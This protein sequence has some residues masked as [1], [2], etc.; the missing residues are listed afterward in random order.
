MKRKSI[1]GV[2]LIECV[3]SIAIIATAIL[4]VVSVFFMGTRTASKI[5]KETVA[6]YLAQ[7]KIEEIKNLHDLV[8]GEE[9][10]EFENEKFKKYKWKSEIT[11]LEEGPYG[12]MYKIKVSVIWKK[13]GFKEDSFSLVTK[14]LRPHQQRE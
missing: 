4:T 8:Q 5:P 1:K 13:E 10:G 6:A 7:Q 3:V 14:L 12:D 2:L 9:E 11:L